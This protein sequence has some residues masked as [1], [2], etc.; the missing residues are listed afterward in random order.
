ML[1]DGKNENFETLCL[2][3]IYSTMCIENFFN[4]G[5]HGCK[6]DYLWEFRRLV[7][8]GWIPPWYRIDPRF[9]YSRLIICPRLLFSLGPDYDPT[10]LQATPNPRSIGGSDQLHLDRLSIRRWAD[11]NNH[12]NLLSK[13]MKRIETYVVIVR[14]VISLFWKKTYTDTLKVLLLFLNIM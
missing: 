6:K 8:I 2:P 5:F 3:Y 13:K 4:H 14:R 1:G 9:I 10:S 11:L 7:G 12:T